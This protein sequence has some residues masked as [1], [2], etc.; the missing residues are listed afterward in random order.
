MHRWRWSGANT[1]RARLVAARRL[2]VAIRRTRDRFG[3]VPIY[4]IC[5]SHAGNIALYALNDPE[6]AAHVSG[7]ITL[8]SPFL[9]S[10][11]RNYA[12]S[13]NILHVFLAFLI[14]MVLGWIFAL[15][16][17]T[18]RHGISFNPKDYSLAGL[19]DTLFI[20]LIAGFAFTATMFAPIYSATS[21]L[22]DRAL[23]KCDSIRDSLRRLTFPKTVPPML[24][25]TNQ[26]DEAGF[27]LRLAT[28]VVDRPIKIW[29][30]ITGLAALIAGLFVISLLLLFI[31]GLIDRWTAGVGQKSGAGVPDILVWSFFTLLI[32]CMGMTLPLAGWIY[33]MLYSSGLVG[34]HTYGG[35]G[36]LD[37]LLSRD[38]TVALPSVTPTPKH[39]VMSWKR[40][41]IEEL[42]RGELNHSRFYVDP[43]SVAAIGGWLRDRLIKA[44]R[45]TPG[46]GTFSS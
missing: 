37:S 33:V 11:S 26:Y 10:K 20:T 17:L 23:S 25:I 36:L 41:L 30:L 18:Y 3:G 1:H 22:Y 39:S 44:D 5:H 13:L 45:R 32:A 27:G 24:V 16:Y 40:A 46:D 42:R 15:G 28:R 38:T 29:K 34:R 21:G 35:E 43:K 31:A 9:L 2:K 8:G 12:R 6:T 14:S 7:L 19:G 4:L